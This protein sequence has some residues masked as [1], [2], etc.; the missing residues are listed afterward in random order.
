MKFFRNFVDEESA[1]ATI[2]YILIL[3]VLV[4]IA[5]LLVRDLIRPVMTRLSESIQSMVSD[6][7]FKSGP[8]MH[9]SPFKR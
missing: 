8:A 1:Q 2:E 4:T 6:K 9:R 7:M 3:A 5:I